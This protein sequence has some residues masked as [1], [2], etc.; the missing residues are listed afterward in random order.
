[1]GPTKFC[2]LFVKILLVMSEYQKSMTAT[3]MD[4]WQ[5]SHGFETQIYIGREKK[6]Q[7]HL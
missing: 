1:M 7:Q 3:Y 5:V 6:G 4:H 2:E